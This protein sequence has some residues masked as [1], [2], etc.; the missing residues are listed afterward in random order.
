MAEAAAQLLGKLYYRGQ[1]DYGSLDGVHITTLKE[2]RRSPKHYRHRLIAP[3][4]DTPSLSLGNSAHIAVLEPERFLRE[5]CMWSERKSN[6]DM[7]PMKGER[8]VN[9]MTANP[10]KKPIKEEEY[11]RA[12][13][14]RDA[15]R[16]DATAMKYLAM[17]RPEVAIQW[18]HEPTGTLCASR[19]D[20]ETK[21]QRQPCIV[22]LKSTRSASEV[23]FP[24]DCARLD[25][26]LQA[27]FYCDAYE[28]ATGMVPLVVV[29]AVEVAPPYDVVTYIIPDDVLQ[30][31]REA[32]TE[33]L[34]RLKEC[35]RDN[36]WPGQGGYS[37]RTLRLPAWAVPDEGG[38]FEDL[39]LTGWNRS[40]ESE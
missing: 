37:E 4:K 24:R 10:G 1:C 26:H 9:F 11:E 20:W 23:W 15:V 8:F 29:I 28:A 36:E 21:I 31:G 33:L 39:G 40:E 17:G 22:D 27:A 16:D 12:I 30:I 35:K 34:E 32:Y 3:R 25:Y 19:V 38:D 7:M 13:T 2:M 5:F 6:G 18:T 14:L